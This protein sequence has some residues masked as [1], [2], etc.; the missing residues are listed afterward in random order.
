ML[1]QHPVVNSQ[2]SS[3]TAWR[4]RRTRHGLFV[5]GH[6]VDPE[7]CSAIRACTY[8]GHVDIN[9]LVVRIDSLNVCA[10]HPEGRFSEV[11]KA[12]KGKFMSVSGN[13]VAL[14]DES[15]PVVL[16]GE[17]YITRLVLG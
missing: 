1:L 16:N 17:V 6:Q 5:H 3:L 15:C 12:R 14:V 2:W 9:Q 11:T 4:S 10:G 7:N 13:L 8:S